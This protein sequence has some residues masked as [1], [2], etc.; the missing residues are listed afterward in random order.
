METAKVYFVN[1][2]QMVGWFGET[3][4]SLIDR[5]ERLWNHKEVN[6]NEWIKPGD[7]V[8]IKT[9]FGSINQ[10]RHL[11]PLYIRKIVDLVTKAKGLPGSP[12]ETGIHCGSSDRGIHLD[13][14][15]S[16]L[17]AGSEK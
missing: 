15:P 7:K 2:E 4:D 16:A 10:T 11:R 12:A 6:P 5:L 13:A 9:H 17:E 3:P 1:T 8:I 14:D